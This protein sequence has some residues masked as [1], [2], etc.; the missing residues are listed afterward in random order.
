M[1]NNINKDIALQIWHFYYGTKTTVS[2][3]AGRKIVKSAYN[4]RNSLYGWNIDHKIP[5]SKGGKTTY[6][7]CCPIN[8]RSNEI[9]ANQSTWI[10]EDDSIWQV[11]KVEPLE[12][13]NK[14][15][16]IIKEKQYNYF[17]LS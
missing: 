14:D 7:N 15:G 12:Y 17:K 1:N 11:K 2:D 16:S 6:G 5:L 9:K 4:D 8:L 10:E 3:Y 13:K